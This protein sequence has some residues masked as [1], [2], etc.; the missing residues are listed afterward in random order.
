[1]SQ[2]PLFF[3]NLHLPTVF[4]V[5]V[6]AALNP[7]AGENTAAASKRRIVMNQRKHMAFGAVSSYRHS[8]H[9]E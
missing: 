9:K 6:I 1:M 8:F 3:S 7:L 4:R 5:L 2:F